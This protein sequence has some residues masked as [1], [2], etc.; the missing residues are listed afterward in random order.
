MGLIVDEEFDSRGFLRKE[1]RRWDLS[2]VRRSQ[3][4]YPRRTAFGGLPARPEPQA[5]SS[6]ATFR[7]TYARPGLGP[8]SCTGCRRGY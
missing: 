2:P 4:D 7:S 3:R 1:R 8:H 6:I 5:A